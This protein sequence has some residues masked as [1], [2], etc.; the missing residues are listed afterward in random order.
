MECRVLFLVVLFNF[1]PVFAATNDVNYSSNHLVQKAW[2]SLTAKD[3]NAAEVY[4]NKTIELYSP[5]ARQMQEHLMAYPV[6][7]KDKVFQYWALNDVGT[8]LLILGEAYSGSGKEQEALKI[9]RK[10]IDEYSYAQCWEPRGWFWKPASVAKDKLDMAARGVDIDFGNYDSNFLVQK[11]WAASAKKDIKIVTIYVNKI[12]EMYGDKAKE[13]QDSLK[14]NTDSSLV[15]K[16]N[17]FN[18]WA[19][20]DV[21]TALFILADTY[22][23]TGHR[24]EADALYWRIIKEYSYAQC[25]RRLGGFWKPA[26]VAQK[27]LEHRSRQSIFGE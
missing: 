18:Y 22:R 7:S 15:Y 27:R 3:F 12:E 17:V 23:K 11:A 10:I 16:Q 6:G 5:Q 4:A 24:K 2:A 19:L 26:Q 25:W 14:H 21:G 1:S 9:Y 13:M 8:A 20:N